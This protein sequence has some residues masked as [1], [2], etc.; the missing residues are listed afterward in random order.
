MLFNSFEF[1]VFFI[2]L[3]LAY[4][5]LPH[6][7]RWLLLLLASYFFYGFWEWHYLGLILISTV[8]DYL[9]GLGIYNSKSKG[10]K[11]SFLL[12]S[13]LSNLGILMTFK[14]YNFFIENINSISNANFS[15]LHFLLPVGISFYTFQTMSY[16]LDLYNGKLEK[17]EKHFGRFALFVTF[18]PQLVAGP[19][20]RASH[21]L[22]QFQRKV[23]LEYDNLSKGLSIILWGLFKKVVI[24]DRLSIFVDEIYNNLGEYGSFAY[25]L[26]TIFFAF[27]IYCDFSGYSDIA[28]GSARVLGFEL[29]INFNKPY[30]AK[31]LREFWQRWH[32]SLSSWFRDYVYIPLGGNKTVKWRW[33]YNIMITFLISGF[34]HGAQWTFIIWGLI[35][36]IILVTEYQFSKRK[37]Q[38]LGPFK[39]MS[40]ILLTFTIVCLTWVFFRANSFSDALLI[41]ES[42]VNINSYD[43]NSIGLYIVPMARNTVYPI[44]ILLGVFFICFLVIAEIR[45]SYSSFFKLPEVI[46][47]AIYLIGIILILTLGVFNT[48][49]FIY[50]QF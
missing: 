28:I 2:V 11:R 17:P 43:F 7:Y 45:F 5:S 38:E 36:G 9:A 25:I 12:I 41:L 49:A 20:E 21:L 50:F 33:Y 42:L 30:L 48:N 8:I 34:W 10:K 24:A 19:I 4:Y 46:K 29:N 6:K 27:Q 23:K 26:A 13:L 39:K 40:K 1:L 31:S 14:Y 16:S 18:F 32:I 3:V 22:P 47:K 35:H 15:Y 37:G 44:D